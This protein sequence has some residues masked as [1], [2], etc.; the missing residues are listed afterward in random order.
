VVDTT[1]RANA[2]MRRAMVPRAMENTTCAVVT[3]TTYRSV[4]RR[5]EFA[6]WP[7]RRSRVTV[8]R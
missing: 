8:A 3:A 1:Y 5:D 7:A 2:V 4:A 6:S